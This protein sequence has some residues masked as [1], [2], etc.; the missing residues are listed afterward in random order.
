MTAG[1][2]LPTSARRIRHCVELA[3]HASVLT[4]DEFDTAADRL[5]YLLNQ[6]GDFC[7]E[8]RVAQAYL[9]RGTQRPNGL[10][11]IDGLLTPHAWALLEPI[12][13]KHAAPGMGNP[14]DTTPCVSG[15]PSEEQKRA[16]TRTG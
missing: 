14:N 9:R 3:T 2:R 5:A 16:D 4:V 13:E 6:D 7:D 10:I 11:P 15:T 1:R 12:L 8:D